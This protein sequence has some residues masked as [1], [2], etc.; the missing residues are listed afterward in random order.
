[1]THIYS[2]IPLLV[3]YAF[4]GLPSSCPVGC[5]LSSVLCPLSPTLSSVLCPLSSVLCPPSPVLCPLFYLL[6]CPL[7]PVL[8]NVLSCHAPCPVACHVLSCPVMSCPV[9][10]VT[11]PLSPVPCPLSCPVLSSVLSPR[12]CL[13]SSWR[14]LAV[15]LCQRKAQT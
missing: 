9:S 13:A 8:A 1:M 2:V 12:L 11:C 3:W 4:Y 14:Y 10:H 7:S 15:G 6:S 5:L